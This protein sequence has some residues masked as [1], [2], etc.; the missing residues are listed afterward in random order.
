MIK[1]QDELLSEL[2]REMMAAPAKDKPSWMRK[3]D[4]ALDVRLQMMKE[5][6]S[7]LSA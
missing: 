7:R 6:D 1:S 5:R 3:I 2:R 4:Q